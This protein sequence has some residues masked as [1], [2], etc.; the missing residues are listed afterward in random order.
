MRRIGPELIVVLSG[1][2]SGASNEPSEVQ[3]ARQWL[4]R[5]MPDAAARLRV[6]ARSRHTIDNRREARLLLHTGPVARLSHRY[7]LARSPG[8]DACLCAAE[9]GWRGDRRTTSRLVVEAGYPMIVTIGGD[10]F[11]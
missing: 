5:P 11:A 6:E 10:G 2:R 9:P 1:G 8:M 7:H 3:V 4:L